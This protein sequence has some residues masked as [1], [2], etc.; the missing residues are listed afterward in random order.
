MP[1]RRQFCTMSL[2]RSNVPLCVGSATGQAMTSNI[3]TVFVQ[4]TP[5]VISRRRTSI[6]L[7]RRRWSLHQP[8]CVYRLS[9]SACDSKSIDLQS[10]SICVGYFELLLRFKFS[11][12]GRFKV[13]L[14][15]LLN[16]IPRNPISCHQFNG[17]KYWT[18]QSC[19][20]RILILISCQIFVRKNIT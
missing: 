2:P 5:Y 17:S 14:V 16:S 20:M 11:L 15:I 8:H 4:F 1:G 7:P 3:S 9:S 6:G 10:V 19:I 12:F 13:A 18:D